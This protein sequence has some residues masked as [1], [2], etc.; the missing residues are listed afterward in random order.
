[1][2]RSHFVTA[3]NSSL[4]SP[5]PVP[6]LRLKAAKRHYHITICSRV[7]ASE[8]MKMRSSRFPILIGLPKLFLPV[9]QVT[10]YLT[11]RT[12]QLALFATPA[13]TLPSISLAT[14]E[15][16]VLSP[17]IMRSAPSRSEK[18]HIVNA[19]DVFVSRILRLNT[20]S[21]PLFI[22]LVWSRIFSPLTVNSCLRRDLITSSIYWGEESREAL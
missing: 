10:S 16:S 22:L 2:T 4:V 8:R 12:G 5:S 3:F 15:T 20:T 13:A 9:T 7:D 19:I 1:M 11:T 6:R 21:F 17:R 18:L 14:G